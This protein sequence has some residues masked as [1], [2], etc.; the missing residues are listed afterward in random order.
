MKKIIGYILAL[1]GFVCMTADAGEHQL[2]WT[3]GWILA[4]CLG[5][6]LLVGKA[7]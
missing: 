5:L 6:R 2:L 1:S 7:K 4:L 3:G